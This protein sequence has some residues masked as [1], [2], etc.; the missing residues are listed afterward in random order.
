[1]VVRAFCGRNQAA[2]Q[3]PGATLQARISDASPE[4]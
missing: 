3:Y 1:M 4:A 2:R